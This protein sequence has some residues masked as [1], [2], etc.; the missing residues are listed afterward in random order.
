VLAGLAGSTLTLSFACSSSNN[1]GAAS[2]TGGAT[3]TGGQSGLSGSGGGTT[4]PLPDGAPTSC[5][6]TS[7]IPAGAVC[8]LDIEGRVI[9]Q[10]GNAVPPMGLV[11]ACGPANCNPGFTDSTGRFVIDVGFHMLTG[12][13]SAQ[14]HAR[15]DYAAFYYQLPADAA[16]PSIDL[17]N[18]RILPMPASGPALNIDR[19]GTPAQSV[20]SGDV[21][22]IVG[23][24]T[25]VRLDVESDAAGD[26]PG[27][28]GTQFRV[29]KI[30]DQFLA[31]YAPASLG[32]KVLY[33]MEPFES[34]FE[35][36]GMMGVEK[37]V[38]LSFVNSTNFPASAAI[39]VLSLGTY[40]Y[41]DWIP[42]GEFTKVAS[43]HV[44]ADG[45]KIDF[46]SGQ[47]IPYLTWVGLRAA[48]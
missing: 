17:R 20:T 33:A 12:T 31:E 46:D 32:I 19:A 43:A 5:S 45:T 27:Q 35:I 26:M 24:M 47:G 40:I 44:S 41:P 13:Y 3:S 34:S 16:G 6:D 36:G 39:D 11:S 1:P 15:P 25:Y 9:D 8:I 48:Q 38:Q 29:L 28:L 2:A 10:N 18:L 4:G 42:P 14:V 37:N 7:A 23:D 21:T 22:L 30:P